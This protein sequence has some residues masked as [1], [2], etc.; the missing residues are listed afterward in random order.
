MIFEY[1]NIKIN[2]QTMGKR[3]KWLLF[4]HGWGGDIQSFACL[5]PSFKNFK[6][7]AV[8]FPPFGCSEEPKHPLTMNDYVEMIK[9]LLKLLKIRKINIIAHSFGGRVALILASQTKLV[10]KLILVDSAGLKPRK[11]LV[12]RLK[13][14]K[15]KALKKLN[16]TPKNAGSED[17]Q[18]LSTT[19]QKTFVNVVNFHLDNVC[20]NITCPV[21]I[22]WG[23]K[24]KSTPIWMAKKLNKLISNSNLVVFGDSGHFSYLNHPQKFCQITKSFLNKGDK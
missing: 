14:L 7:L 15:Y 22:V 24:D 6:V 5:Y 13:I 20:K 9:Q 1:K 18:H 10:N 16:K 23:K 17:Y 11:S 12:V 21:L 4:L 19:M 3:G 8:D 2:Y